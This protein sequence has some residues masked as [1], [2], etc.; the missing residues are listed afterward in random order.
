MGERDETLLERL[1]EALS[2]RGIIKKRYNKIRAQSKCG[3]KQ[4]YIY[5]Y[6]IY[7]FFTDLKKVCQANYLTL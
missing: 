5:I 4:S 6:F 1:R 3:V 2:A 7:I